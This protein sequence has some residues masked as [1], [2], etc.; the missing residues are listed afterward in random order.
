MTAIAQNF[1]TYKGDAAIPT[2]TVQDGDKNPIDISLVSQITWNLAR[3]SSSSPVL[4]KTKTGT[5]TDI[6]F[7]T[8]GTD[9]QFQVK[10]T[11]SDTGALSGNY[12]HTATITDPSGNV[13]TVAVG[14]MYVGLAP[15][16]TYDPTQLPTTS[17]GAITLQQAIM[18][19]RLLIGDTQADDQQQ[20]DEEIGA[21]VGMFCRGA[22]IA[23]K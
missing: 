5:N 13:T 14:T 11:A 21:T 17:V 20:W 4:T 6:T 12:F 23:L 22:A 18:A 16:W 15:T 7:V 3:T 2:F 8:N 9:G 1:K 10:V 19:T